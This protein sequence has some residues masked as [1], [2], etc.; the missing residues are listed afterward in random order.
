[1]ADFTKMNKP[2]LTAVI[3]FSVVVLIYFLVSPKY[4]EFKNLQVRIGEKEAE[5]NGKYE[6][7]AEVNKAYRELKKYNDGIKRIENAVPSESSFGS[8]VY[9]FQQK[10]SENGLIA[11]KI[12]LAKVSASDP[13][14]GIKEID[15]SLNLMGTYSSFKNFIASLERSAR[16]F[17]ADNISFYYSFGAS[18]LVSS[19]KAQPVSQPIY[20][21]T[22]DVKTQSY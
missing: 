9:F 7:Y 17:E 4:N 18:S 16:L 3:I 19:E 13:Q 12:F 11:K 21:F 5:Y 14:A 22:L 6:Y 10:A 2:I 8:L 20:S 1:M 15:F